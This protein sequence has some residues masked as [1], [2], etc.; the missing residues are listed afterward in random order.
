ME[1][2][3][4]FIGEV[5]DGEKSLDVAAG[6]AY[7]HSLRRYHG[8]IIRGIFNVRDDS[9]HLGGRGGVRSNNTSD[10]WKHTFLLLMVKGVGIERKITFFVMGWGMHA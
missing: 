2:V 8:W 4:H 6:K 1:F 10:I 9:L 5:C 3:Q 7:T